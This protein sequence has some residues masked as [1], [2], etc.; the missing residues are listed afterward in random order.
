MIGP[1]RA[2]ALAARILIVDDE[3]RDRE[4]LRVMLGQEGFSLLTASSGED[5]LA[6]TAR[7]QPDIVLLDVMMPGMD[8][9]QVVAKLKQ[10]P[11]TVNIPVIMITALDD[12]EALIRGLDAG[13]EDFLSKPLDRAELKARVKNLLRLKAYGDQQRE[14]GEGLEGEVSTRTAQVIES[15]KRYRQI[16]ESTTDGIVK[17]DVAAM[18]VFANGRF[19]DMLGYELSELIGNSAF[20]FMD[21]KSAKI[22]REALGR[23]GKGVA[24]AYDICLRRKDGSELAISLASTPILDDQDRYVGALASARDV[25]EQRRLMAQ[26][27]LSDRMASI[28][29]LAAGV[30]HEINS[31]LACVLANLDLATRDVLKIAQKL[32]VMVEFGEVCEEL[33]DAREATDRIRS[34]VRDLKI[35]SH[36]GEEKTGPVDIHRVLDS[37]L[38]MAWNEIRHRATLVKDYGRTPLVE[39]SEARLG[40]V[41]LNLVIN[42]AQAIAEGNAQD[43]EIRV[44]TATDSAGRA[45]IEIAD[46][47]PGM[48]PEVLSRLF[49]PFFTTKPVG[50]G[51][52]LGLSI[53]HRIITS[54]G[55]SIEVTSEVGKGTTFRISLPA[56]LAKVAQVAHDVTVDVTAVRRGRILVVDDE[57][58]IGKALQRAMSDEH[59]V[60]ATT[61]ASQALESITVGE[62][63]DIILC[64][65]M[66]P[67]MT[68]M[69]LHEA[70]LRVAPE[71][72]SRMIFLSGGDFTERARAF[73][74]TT[75]NT[76]L[77]KPFDLRQLRALINDRIR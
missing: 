14:Y 24:E 70:L 74:N 26:L 33:R 7:E 66:M 43:N 25:T 3:R 45:T 64:D 38:R 30:A 50:V 44:S 16:V 15:E 5:A 57:P 54:C 55:G 40:Q 59:D 77:E 65:L 76:R 29:M 47:G 75:S 60:I 48:P 53:C 11:A 52:G 27:T 19:A 42:A 72:A 63:F 23:R 68:G 4:L 61:S 62:R 2:D 31:P 49:T 17:L 21:Q 9:Y 12:R 69:D 32:G 36:S 22:L 18:I 46:T 58:M 71:Q 6:I 37:T 41:F 73:S 10:D 28:G 35:F 20:S 13:A 1:S 51:T 8:G 56:S 34:I 67:Q 39:A